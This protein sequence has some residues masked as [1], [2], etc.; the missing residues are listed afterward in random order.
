MV[1][2]RKSASLPK[3]GGST[4]GTAR[5]V[6]GTAAPTTIATAA[7]SQASLRGLAGIPLDENGTLTN[8]HLPSGTMPGAHRK[9][10]FNGPEAT[11]ADRVPRQQY[12]RPTMAVV[13]AQLPAGPTPALQPPV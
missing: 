4:N 3:G 9:L 10:S 5:A 6:I 2:S 12:R 7:E 8:L 13:D 11:A 1:N